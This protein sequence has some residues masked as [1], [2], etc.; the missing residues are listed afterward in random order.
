MTERLWCMH[1]IGPD[2][3]HAAPDQQTAQAWADELNASIARRMSEME[4]D[5]DTPSVRAEAAEW[6]W[7]P[8]AHAENLAKGLAERA[9]RE[10]RRSPTLTPES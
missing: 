6:P 1:V 7:S 5:E 4:P 3:V 9:A 10:A 2:D 8:E